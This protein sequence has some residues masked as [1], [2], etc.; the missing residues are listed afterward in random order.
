MNLA[1]LQARVSSSRLPGKVLADIQGK[2]L[3]IREIDR[4]NQSKLIGGVIVATSEEPSDDQLADVLKEFGVSF[5]RG[6]LNN[7][8][9]RFTQIITDLNPSC[10][11]R[12][13]ADCPLI[14]PEIIDLVIEAHSQSGA[15]Y[16]SN[17]LKPTYPDGLDVECFKPKILLKLASD[18]PTNME[19]EHVTYGLYTRQGYC[20]LNS[21]EQDVDLSSLRWTVDTID[22]LDFVRK[23]YSYFPEKESEFVQKDILNLIRINPSI[24]RT[25][26]H[27]KRNYGLHVD[28]VK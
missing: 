23:V 27:L 3:I 6:S 24:S 16:T 20:V 1:I 10:V 4:I 21:V 28:G 7:V 14:D 19:S 15:D 25:D 17:T 5:F 18:N 22:D 8:L 26:K 9:S 2:P 12:L 13:T 11:I